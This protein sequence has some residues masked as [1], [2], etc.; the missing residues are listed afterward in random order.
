MMRDDISCG[1]ERRACVA[2]GFGVCYV[3]L[4]F[5]EPNFNE[6]IKPVETEERS[7]RE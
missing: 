6:E 4:A 2:A 3:E 1:G 5:G 7:E